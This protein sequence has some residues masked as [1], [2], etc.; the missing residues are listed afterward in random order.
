V[1]SQPL[2]PPPAPKLPSVFEAAG[3]QLQAYATL[4]ATAGVERGL[5]GPR[6]VPRI[7]DRHLLNSA[8]LSELIPQ[9]VQVLDVGSGAG[10]PGLPLAIVRSDLQVV[11][12]EPLLRRA[13]FLD[14]AVEALGLGR[15]VIVDRGRAEERVNT[16]SSAIVTARA[17]APLDRLAAWC[18]P[19]TKQGG[20]LLALKGAQAA[21]EIEAGRAVISSLGGGEP[22]IL[23]CGAGIV[24]PPTTV[25]R[26]VRTG[27][28]SRSS[29]RK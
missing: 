5:L 9:G 24:E 14:E 27:T 22:E 10:L 28:G 4:L 17:V 8:V 21:D 15:R 6:E 26:I 11:L 19:L 25:V 7:W 18:L 1:S 3:E 2:P 29:R 12:L 16:Y 23:T 13:T 20:A